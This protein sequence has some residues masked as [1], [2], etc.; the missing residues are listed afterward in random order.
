[1][2]CSGWVGVHK[3]Q[4]KFRVAA[5][6]LLCNA[7]G[8]CNCMHPP[9]STILHTLPASCTLEG[10]T[11]SEGICWIHD[12]SKLLLGETMGRLPLRQRQTW[13]W[14]ARSKATNARPCSSL[15]SQVASQYPCMPTTFSLRQYTLVSPP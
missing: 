15:G 10:R 14:V 2:V 6:T 9:F 13:S 4:R 1:M 8:K 5:S 11:T 7:S 3:S 12:H